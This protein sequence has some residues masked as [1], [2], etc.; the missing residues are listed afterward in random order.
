MDSVQEDF[1]GCFLKRMTWGG[2]FLRIYNLP[3]PLAAA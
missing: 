3:R 1:S 2:P